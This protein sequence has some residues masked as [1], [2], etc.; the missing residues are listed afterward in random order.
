[1][2]SGEKVFNSLF[3]DSADVKSAVTLWRKSVGIKGNERVSR[4]MLLERM[5]KGEEAGEVSCVCY[6]SSPYLTASAS[7]F[8]L[9][10]CQSYP[11]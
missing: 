6:K 4:A 7:C 10:R 2:N 3:G 9:L 1:M 5:V 11:Y 8:R